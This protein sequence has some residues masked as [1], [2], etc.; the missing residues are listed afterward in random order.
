M[1]KF[2]PKED[3]SNNQLLLGN[4]FKI[5]EKNGNTPRKLTFDFK[6]KIVNMSVGTNHIGCITE[7]KKVLFH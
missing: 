5:S 7:D 4:D 3:Q 1:E 2:I 6:S